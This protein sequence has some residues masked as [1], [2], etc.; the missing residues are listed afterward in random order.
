LERGWLYYINAPGPVTAY[1]SE[2]NLRFTQDDLTLQI[3]YAYTQARQEYLPGSPQL[4][5]TPHNRLSTS[6]VYEAE[7][8]W[9]AG[10]EGF[11][12]SAQTL[13]NGVK[14]QAFWTFDLMVQRS[15][16]PWA[17]LLNLENFTDTRQSRFGPLF[18]G[19]S[20]SPVFNEIYAPLE[21]RVISVAVR[22]NL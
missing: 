18:T 1:G 21:G 2:T 17:A 13:D 19:T 14:G 12:T 6:L 7:P 4:P 16:G 8:K 22:Y 10:V 15:W 3:G 5:L 11:Y 20:R 9:K